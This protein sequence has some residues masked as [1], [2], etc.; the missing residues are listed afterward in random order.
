MRTH[1]KTCR[2]LPFAGL[3]ASLALLAACGGGGGDGGVMPPPVVE[4]PEFRHE[5]LAGRA[6]SRIQQ[7]GERL[8][9]ATDNGLFGKGIGGN[10]WQPLG[11]ADYHVQGLAILDEQHLLASVIPGSAEPGRREPRLYESVNGGANWL[12]VDN[13]FGAGREHGIGIWALAH[14]A[15]TGRLYATGRDALA[16]SED[17]GRR[18][19]LLAGSWDSLDP[20]NMALTLN[21]A[22]G[23]VWYGG[24]RATEQLVLRRYDLASGTTR[25][26]DSL[27]LP[28]PATIQGVTI[29]PDHPER[30]IAA[31]EGGILQ[32]FNNGE[33]WS[34]PLG[35]VDY[36]FYFEVALDPA[37]SRILYTAGWTKQFDL[38][39]PLIVEISRDS[40]ASWSS[41]ELDDPGLFGGALS[42]LAVAEGG[43]T[44]LYVGLYRGGIMKVL[45]PP[46]T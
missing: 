14:D 16:V 40:G 41:F 25:S 5:G 37:D 33:T 2:V 4:Q 17:L 28:A 27:L 13:D 1:T 45:P 44:V 21:G 30:V 20:P 31:G 11:L 18:W 19:Q 6:V 43:R 29:D 15:A 39:Q 23:Q 24:Q 46:A 38:P 34:R 12:P 26:F 22:R 42:V 35:D 3:L 7:H 8:F 32:T 9:A 10:D 36:R